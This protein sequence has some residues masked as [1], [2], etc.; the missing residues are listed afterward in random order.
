M[1]ILAPLSGAQAWALHTGRSRS[2]PCIHRA[3]GAVRQHS[4]VGLEYHHLIGKDDTTL[5]W[6]K[7]LDHY[8][9]AS[10][11][12]PKSFLGRALGNRDAFPFVK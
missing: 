12:G 11:N 8:C 4:I 2:R 3:A 1:V 6:R 10:I 7:T 5:K 9:S